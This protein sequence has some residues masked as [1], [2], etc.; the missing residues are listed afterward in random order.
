MPNAERIER[1]VGV[2]LTLITALMDALEV[3]N[4]LLIYIVLMAIAECDQQ[5][6]IDGAYAA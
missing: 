1:V 3:D 4:K 2:Q 6:E 5:L